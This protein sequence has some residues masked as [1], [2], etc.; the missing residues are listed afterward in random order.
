VETVYKPPQISPNEILDDIVENY[1]SD[2]RR[3]Y[4]EQPR[5]RLDGVFI[6]V[7]HY[8]YSTARIV[9][10]RTIHSLYLADATD[11]AKMLGLMSVGINCIFI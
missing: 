10:F 5:V 7:C 2:Y 8:M 6:A 11:K 3:V 1:S 4:I 9:P